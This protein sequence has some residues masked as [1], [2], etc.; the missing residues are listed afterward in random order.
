MTEPLDAIGLLEVSSIALGHVS[1]DAMLKAADV[2][3]LLAR[4][5]CS[6]KFIIV[7]AGDVAAC[8]SAVEAGASHATGGLIEKR[9]IAHVHPSVF[10]AISMAV[11]LDPAE[12]QSLGVIE[13]F[14][15]SSIVDVADTAAKAAAVTLFRIH[16][17]MAIGGKG[18]VM[19]TGDVAS[20]EAA[21]SAGATVAAEEGIL[22]AKSVI[23][24]PRKELFREFV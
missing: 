19:L 22:V 13:T 20:V 14:S 7:V 5:I 1:E 9:V 17:A 12:A 11:D 6:G 2:D 23:A 3:L 18:Y 15:A 10:P 8:E 16:M 21:V 4:T 24:A